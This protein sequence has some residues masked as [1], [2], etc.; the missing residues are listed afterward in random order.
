MKPVLCKEMVF[1]GMFIAFCFCMF[2]SGVNALHRRRGY[3]M[4]M[5]LILTPTG[6]AEGVCVYKGRFVS[7][8]HW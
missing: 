1:G 5:C 6:C 7:E 2:L 4:K 3:M 8:T